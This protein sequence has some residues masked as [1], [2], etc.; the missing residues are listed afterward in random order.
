MVC[1]D[2]FIAETDGFNFSSGGKNFGD[3]SFKFDMD[4]GILEVGVEDASNI[5]GGLVNGENSAVFAGV[6]VEPTLGEHIEDI[7]ICEPEAGWSDEIS[8][9][10]A[11][12][13]EDGVDWAVV[14]DVAF[15]SAGDEDFCADSVGFFE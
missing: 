11:K 8:F 6:N 10:F 7:L 14:G 12:G 1:G 9:V 4:V 2:S 3:R 13:F 15:A 5:F